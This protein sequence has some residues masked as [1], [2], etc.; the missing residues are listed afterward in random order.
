[1]QSPKQTNYDVII[2]GAG[3]VG[4]ALAKGLARDGRSVLLLEKKSELSTHSKA[5]T[6]WSGTQDVVE[7]LGL[8]K[9]FEKEALCRDSI[10]LWDADANRA[11]A[12]LPLFELST[13]TKHARLLLLPQNVTEK[14]FFDGLASEKKVKIEFDAN[15][16]ELNDDR[17]KVEVKFV[18]DG[19]EQVCTGRFAI[20]C[21]GAH[22]IVRASLG[23][24]LEG[25]TYSIKAGLVDV[26]LGDQ[27]RQYEYPRF[28]T[29][30][31]LGFAI[32]AS[33]DM[34]RI[35][36]IDKVTRQWDLDDMT[37]EFVP[38]LFDQTKYEAIWKSEFKLHRRTSEKFGRGNMVLAGDAAHLNSPVGG[39]GMNSGIQDTEVLREALKQAF[40]LDSNAPLQ[41]YARQRKDAVEKGV[42][43][44][45]GLM[46]D[47]LFGGGG[48]FVK[49]VVKTIGVAMRVPPIRH[50]FLRRAM[51]LNNFVS[52]T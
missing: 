6:L 2:V 25:E 46:T 14:V 52:K 7:R 41:E 21:D 31:G 33:P 39:Q 3:P 40:D 8:L 23:F 11:L 22:S 17:E 48:R 44:Y 10:Q 29:K 35:I 12:N 1:M 15:V 50:A 49:D 9:A 51:M 47:V 42:N 28:S 18:K 13:E 36:F 4:L 32:K 45:T 38:A 30:D 20:G 27:K 16:I 24:H 19:R 5:V 26:K 43:K 37:K 34:W